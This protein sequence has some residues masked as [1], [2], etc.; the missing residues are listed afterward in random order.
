[1]ESA[2]VI[3]PAHL[4]RFQLS[5]QLLAV[6][7]VSPLVH[8]VMHAD[9][10]HHHFDP[11]FYP[12][13]Q[14]VLAIMNNEKI[15][16]ETLY[17]YVFCS[18]KELGMCHLRCCVPVWCFAKHTLVFF[19]CST[20]YHL[21]LDN[22]TEQVLA[23]LRAALSTYFSMWLSLLLLCFF[24]C[25]ENKWSKRTCHCSN[26]NNNN[27]RRNLLK[28]FE[29]WGWQ[30][31]QCHNRHADCA[32]YRCFVGRVGMCDRSQSRASTQ[33]SLT[34]PYSHSQRDVRG[35]IEVLVKPFAML[36]RLLSP[37]LLCCAG[38]C[39]VFL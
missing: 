30:N 33:V 37:P 10:S 12:D 32:I 1:M 26:N 16:M 15:R 19:V 24:L 8:V 2:P 39:F 35:K 21:V 20:V 28:D 5:E 29:T 4:H 27:T 14:N 31:Q 36:V 7:W 17:S 34:P 9:H 38:T 13:R 11:S 18:Q 23:E 6:R 25:E 22:H 3:R